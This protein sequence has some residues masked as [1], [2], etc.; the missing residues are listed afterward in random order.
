MP[1][2]NALRHAY[3]AMRQLQRQTI[4]GQHAGTKYGLMETTGSSVNSWTM[5]TM[6]RI[7]AAPTRIF[8][9][10]S[11]LAKTP[12]H[13]SRAFDITRSGQMLACQVMTRTH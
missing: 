2:R 11:G 8:W 6:R 9:P 10:V 5:W 3:A 12:F 7:P 4:V 13:P 1:A